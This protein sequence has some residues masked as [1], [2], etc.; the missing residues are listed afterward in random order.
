MKLHLSGIMRLA[1]VVV[2]STV[3]FTVSARAGKLTQTK[4]SSRLYTQPD[5]SARGGIHGRIKKHGENTQIL[6]EV[7]AV[8][9]D[10]PKLV[11]QGV[12]F[13]D[14]KEFSFKGL[15]VAKY[16]LMLLCQTFFYEGFK[17]TPDADS[18]TPRD[19]EMIEKVITK[20]IPFFNVKKI[21]RCEGITGRNGAA[22]CVLQ[23][24]RTLPV[25][26]QDGTLHPEIQVRSIRLACLEDVGTAGWQM[27]STRE[28][29]RMEVGPDDLKGVLP[30][31][32][33][34]ALG[35]IRVMD[36]IK[37]LGEIDLAAVESL[38]P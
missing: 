37:E 25:T 1:A 22:R 26:L 28:I 20:S 33:L 19:R 12:V 34:P 23:E 8:S 31:A 36:E 24:M 6:R 16:D 4:Q 5:S 38:K 35:Q 7:F 13:G 3:M 11:Y 18:L 10:N 29:I 9:P 2:L 32:C 15:P 30:H 14:G 21:H 17:L 27:A